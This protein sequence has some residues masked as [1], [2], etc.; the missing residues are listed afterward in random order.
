[1]KMK[2]KLLATWVIFCILVLIFAIK[3]AINSGQELSTNSIRIQELSSQV[4]QYKLENQ[5][6]RSEHEKDVNWLLQ[7]EITINVQDYQIRDLQER[8]NKLKEDK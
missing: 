6:L 8:L 2:T 1:M 5:C 4:E 7:Q 3:Y